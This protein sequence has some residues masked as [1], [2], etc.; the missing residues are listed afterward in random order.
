M[1]TETTPIV[2]DQDKAIARAKVR[3]EKLHIRQ[4]LVAAELAWYSA[5]SEGRRPSK[6]E[7]LTRKIL[8]LHVAMERAQKSLAAA[9]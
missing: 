7:R 2:K 5:I 6:K 3:V 8:R 1:K 4:A 9:K